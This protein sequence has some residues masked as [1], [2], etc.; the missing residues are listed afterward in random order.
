MSTMSLSLL[1][2]LPEPLPLHYAIMG[3]SIFVLCSFV[4]AILVM[5]YKP[6]Q[7]LLVHSVLK[8]LLRAVPSDPDSTNQNL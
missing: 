1:C 6:S 3:I 7:A 4:Q 8:Q 5:N 2:L